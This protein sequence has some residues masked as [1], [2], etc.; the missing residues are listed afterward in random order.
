MP[1]NSDY[2]NPYDSEIN[3]SRVLCFLGELQGIKWTSSDYA[4][5]H[6]KA[7]QKTTKELLDSATAELCGKLKKLPD[8]SEC[9]LEL[10]MWWRDHQKA[11]KERKQKENKKK[12]NEYLK[13]VALSKLTKEEKKALGF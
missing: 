4:G 6:K 1:C 7:Y 5:F 9:S 3:Y 13:Q 10:Q 8:I 12:D 2:M 11:D